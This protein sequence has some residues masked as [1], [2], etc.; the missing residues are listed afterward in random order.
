MEIWF[1]KLINVT[2]VARTREMFNEALTELA[3]ELGFEYYA[4][5]NLQPVGTFAVSNYSPEW[6]DRYFSKSFSEIDPVVLIAKSTMRAFTWS[7]EN[8]RKVRSRQVR[9]FYLDAAGFGIRSGITI[10][11]A[12]AFRRMA[13]LT[14]ASHKPSLSLNL[15]IDPVAAATA[16]AQLHVRI[17]QAE[18]EPTAKPSIRMTAKQALMLKWSAEG[19]SMRDIA[20][21]EN[22]TYANVNFHMN[23]ARRK[24]DASTQAQATALATKL[25]II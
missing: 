19:K 10:P 22:M 20:T 6:Q 3:R 12:T 18:L 16:V 5:L 23:N 14:I 13:M 24:L 4:Y 8:T 2:A 25:R 1:Q 11:V 9:Q 21:I 15:D 7:S 17:E